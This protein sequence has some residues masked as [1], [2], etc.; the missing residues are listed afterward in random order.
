MVD[1]EF[2][3]HL[4]NKD[5]VSIAATG[6]R[7]FE[8]ALAFD[9]HSKTIQFKADDKIELDLRQG[10]D[11]LHDHDDADLDHH[12]RQADH[13]QPGTG[14]GRGGEQRPAPGACRR[15]SSRPRTPRK[16]AA[17]EQAL[18]RDKDQAE[19]DKYKKEHWFKGAF[20]PPMVNGEYIPMLVNWSRTDDEDLSIGRRTA[21]AG[22]RIAPGTS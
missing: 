16:K 5:I 2:E 12:R 10:R 13:H 9:S 17:D 1:G 7:K 3:E 22:S 20:L 11:D 15:R 4:I 21:W 19:Y 6:D 18:Q 14:G 8:T